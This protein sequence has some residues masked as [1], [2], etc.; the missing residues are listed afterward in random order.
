M[1]LNE[2]SRR[3][4]AIQTLNMKNKRVKSFALLTSENPMG[5]ELS[6]RDNKELRDRLENYL[7]DGNYAWFPVRGQY[8]SRENSYMIYNISLDDTLEIGYKFNQES[9]IFVERDKEEVLYQYW[10]K[11]ESGEYELAHTREEYLDM[12]DSD[13]FYT[14][15]SRNFKFQIPFFDG[16]DENKEIMNEQIRYLNDVLDSRNYS[17][18]NIENKIEMTLESDRS[19]S[20]KYRHRGSLYGGR[21]GRKAVQ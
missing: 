17:N 16:S 2:T 10:E 4:K 20:S 11:D 21:F 13:D 1:L 8:G 18:E 15:I 7:S 9:V 6:K 5:R 14:Q 12:V 3:Q 19:G